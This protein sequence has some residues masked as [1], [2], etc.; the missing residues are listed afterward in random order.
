MTQRFPFLSHRT[1][2]EVWAIQDRCR[3]LSARRTVQVREEIAQLDQVGR[4]RALTERESLRLEAL[5]REDRS[6]A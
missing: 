2:A 5:L 1:V 4:T 6:A 3:Q